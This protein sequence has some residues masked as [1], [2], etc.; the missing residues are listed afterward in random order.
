MMSGLGNGRVDDTS[1]I[2]R[3]SDLEV[4]Y[5]SVRALKGVDLALGR[6]QICVILGANGAGK[7]SIIR[8]IIGLVRP[9]GG[10][11]EF[12]VGTTIQGVEPHRINAL[13]IAWVPEGRQIFSN[14]TVRENLVMGA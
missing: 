11:I 10:T 14:L 4:L 12:P 9:R 3:V 7:S 1:V 13:G 6:A 8:S 2:L 5:G